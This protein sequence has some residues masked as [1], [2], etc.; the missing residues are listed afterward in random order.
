[1]MELLREPRDNSRAVTVVTHA[2]KNLRLC[3]KVVVMGRGGELTFYGEP[4]AA[5]AFFGTD[6][7][8]GIYQALED[9]PPSSG[10]ANSRAG[11]A[12]RGRR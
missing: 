10:A 1:M 8:D 5:P 7:F 9:R 12:R 6:D 3:D 2:T 4:E 11:P